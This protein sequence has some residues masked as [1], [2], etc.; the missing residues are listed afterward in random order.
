MA[1]ACEA[2]RLS[3]HASPVAAAVRKSA[4]PRSTSAR[5]HLPIILL[6]LCGNRVH[7]MGV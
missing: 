1:Q 2:S 6:R 4:P 5:A 7:V 3:L